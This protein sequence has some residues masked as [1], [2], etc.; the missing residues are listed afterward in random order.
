MSLAGIDGIEDGRLDDVAA[1]E[2]GDPSGMLR[3]VATSG[4][5]VRAARTAAAEAITSLADG[6]RPRAVVVAGM[7]GSGIS[8]D[9][10]AA[11]AGIGSSV[12]LVTHRGFGLPGWVGAADLV[13][14][15]S[16]SGATEE[17]LSAAE[18]AARRGARMLGVGAE[19]S[20]LADLVRRARS[21][22]VAVPGGSQP[23]AML[24]ALAV[25]LVVAADALGVLTV[26]P[27][28]YDA[29]ADGLDEIAQ[30]CRPASETFVN[31][32]KLL[33]VELAGTLPV[34]WGTTPLAGVAAYRFAC[35]LAENAKYPAVFGALPEVLHNQVVAFDGPFVAGA[36]DE[37]AFFR[38]RVESS[39][40]GAK[41]RL[42]VLQDG[43]EPDPIAA[44]RSVALELATE[45]GL[46]TSELT[47][48]GASPL[49]RL[50][51]LIGVADFA[52]V[53]LALLL[54]LDPTPVGPIVE[55]KARV[56]R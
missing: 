6:D 32:A 38:D 52:S 24:W 46:A 27:A 17:T 47:T 53:Y 34:I 23:R 48:E 1:L 42:V 5:Q 45:R 11:V 35:Q 31:P 51:S 10:L 39:E 21:P 9:V 37:E 2:A 30:R 36:A 8:G 25:P 54:G 22:Y 4:A 12:P 15:V 16:C 40:S 18:E 41:L 26:P 7:G 28:S 44:R 33:A 43:E 3:D 50:A 14:V 55:L 20:P 49:E 56:R 19:D 29:A 13:A